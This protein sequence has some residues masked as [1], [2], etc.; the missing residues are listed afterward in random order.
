MMFKEVATRL[1]E[2]IARDLSGPDV[3]FPTSFELTLR[4]QGLLKSPD[5]SIDS[6]AELVRTE[7]LMSAKI[8]SY[9]NSAALRGASPEITELSTAIMRIGFDAVRTVSYTLSVE[10]IIRSKHMQPFQ[11]LSKTIWEHSLGVAAVARRLAKRQRMNGEKGFFLGMIHD[12][13]AF[14]LLFR[15]S[16]DPQLAADRD[17]LIEL[18]YQW[19]DG[20]GHAL[21]SAMGQTDDV[22]TAV[23]DHEAPTTL[24]S[25]ANWTNILACADALSER[26]ADWV[27]AELRA[28]RQRSISET[29][30]DTATREEIL[31]EAEADLA[32]LR[33]ALF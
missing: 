29:L 16:Q 15:C 13:G 19:H 2:Q 33:S 21:L 25:L 5:V 22:L 11:D 32:S 12:I 7:P 1:L 26:Y 31:A 23:Q 30:L 14:Y 17:N 10:Q 27:P 24:A 6:L 9:A 4:V 28:S 18:V 8:L 3:V 20:I